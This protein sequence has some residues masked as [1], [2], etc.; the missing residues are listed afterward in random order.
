MA[1]YDYNVT[2]GY[3]TTVSGP[4]TPH[5]AEDIGTPFHTPITSLFPGTVVHEEWK[6]WGGQI[7]IQPDPVSGGK[8]LP[9]EYFYH[10]DTMNVKPGQHVTT[11]D[12]LGLSGGENPGYPGAQH[13]AQ[14][15]YSTGPHTHVGFFQQWYTGEY[16]GVGGK[17][18]RN[19]IPE[20]PDIAPFIQS[21][22]SGSVVPFVPTITSGNTSAT[23]CA[24]GDFG[25]YANQVGT[26]ISGA[27]GVESV[28]DALYRTGFI[29]GGVVLIII[30]L[31]MLLKSFTPGI[32]IGA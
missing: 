9:Q 23:S 2:H 21:A 32:S 5:F 11:H 3:S 24:L 12:V 27:T 13:P 15:Q 29:L 18:Y 4:D 28:S 8:Q 14:P 31:V 25:C 16:E 19:T 20:G 10:L 1:W 22:K 6:P 26:Q 17:I 30:G 7:F